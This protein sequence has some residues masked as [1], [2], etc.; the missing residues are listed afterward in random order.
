GLRATVY[1]GAGRIGGNKILLE[2]GGRVFLDFGVDFSARN[3][4]FS[5]FL[6]PRSFSLVEDY[7]L[8]GVVPALKGLY[9]EE[10]APTYLHSEN[11]FADA[12]IISHA[13]LDHYGHAGLLRPDIPVYMGEGTK[14]LLEAREEV[15]PNRSESLFEEDSEREIHGFRTGDVFEAAGMKFKPVHV[16][17]SVPASYGLIVEAGSGVLA[18]TGDIRAHGPRRDMTQD[19]VEACVRE[20]VETLVVEGTRIDETDNRSEDDVRAGMSA[21]VRNA[22]DRLVSVVVG[23]MDF[24]RLHTVLQVA[25]ENDRVPA[26]SLHHAHI[27]NKLGGANLRIKVP[28]MRDDKILVYLERRGSGTYAKSDYQKWMAALAESAPTVKEEDVRTNQSKY[29]MVL[30]KSEDIIDLA[31]IKP[32]AGSPFILST[33]EPHSEEQVIEM[34]KIK[35]WVELL[36]L[37][38]HHIHSSGHAS[39]TH[40]IEMIKQI[41]P[42]QVIPVHTEH[43]EV[44]AKLLECEK[45]KVLIPR[46]G[47]PLEI[48]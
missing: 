19:F 2:E 45:T 40:I 33:S 30:S 9:S 5:M 41:Q 20:G 25:E 17:H 39:G 12:V 46:S 48:F 42:R 35:N 29:I 38:Y 36:Q 27:L 32:A 47:E 3:A 6:R 1:G 10:T 23:M 18:Y 37:R 21:V 7:V 26:I 44:F 28:S 13:H 4:Y 31:S 43:P 22:G 34:D 8:T 16:D 11:P 15:R 24:D 14:V